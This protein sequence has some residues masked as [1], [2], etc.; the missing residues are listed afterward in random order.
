MPYDYFPVCSVCGAVDEYV[1]KTSQKDENGNH[2]IQTLCSVCGHPIS[3]VEAQYRSE[4]QL[5]Y[6]PVKERSENFFRELSG[7]ALIKEAFFLES[8]YLEWMKLEET[9][10]KVDRRLVLARTF[11]LKELRRRLISPE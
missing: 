4:K 9:Q 6:C 2:F 8:L 10:G 7:D 5:Q 11:C 1:A 3:I